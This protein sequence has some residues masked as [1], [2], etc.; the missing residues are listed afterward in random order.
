MGIRDKLNTRFGRGCQ[1]WAS[2]GNKVDGKLWA[3]K[4][5]RRRPH[6]TTDWDD[7]AVV[8]GFTKHVAS[9]SVTRYNTA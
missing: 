8:N 5:G 3:I 6:D 7:L 4:Q 1:A 9:C 2:A